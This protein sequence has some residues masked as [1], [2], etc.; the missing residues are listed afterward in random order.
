MT[1]SRT[2][3]PGGHDRPQARERDTLALRQ[4]LE[5]HAEQHTP[6]P[7]RLQRR[8]DS[9]FSNCQSIGRE[10]FGDHPHM[11]VER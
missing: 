7:A 5:I 6:D 3:T 8:Q 11:E 10:A 9:R 1:Q 2:D 4:P